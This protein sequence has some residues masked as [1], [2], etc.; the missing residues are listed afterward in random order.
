LKIDRRIV[1]E[2]LI[3]LAT[4][5]LI[6]LVWAHYQKPISYNAGK[7]WEGVGYYQVAEQLLEG[8]QVAAEGP[9]VYRVGT[10]LLVSLLNI[11]DIFLGFQIVNTIANVLTLCLLWFWLRLHLKDSRVR[12]GL[13][14]LFLLQWDTPVHWLYFFPAHT[15]PW[16]WTFL[17]A[18]LICLHYLAQ[19]TNTS[20]WLLALGCLSAVGVVFREVAL[21]IPL[22]LLFLHN[23][24][25]WSERRWK[26]HVPPAMFFLPLLCA[27]LALVLVRVSVVQTDDYSFARTAVQWV[28]TKSLLSYL[29]GW[30]LAYGPVV[31]LPI[32][33]FKQT[34]AFLRQSQWMTVYLLF[35]ALMGYVG[36]SDTERLL[37]WSMPIVF[38]LIGKVFEENAPL[39]RSKPLLLMLIAVEL[40]AVRAFLPTPDYTQ[41]RESHSIPLFTPL[42]SDAYFMDLFSF[43]GTPSVE[44]ISLLQYLAFAGMFGTWIALRRRRL[45]QTVSE[46][47]IITTRSHQKV[48]V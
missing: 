16:L 13:C 33:F 7:G 19:A 46:Q 31:F 18:G 25:R 20:R 30:M 23:P 37:Y 47:A 15:D 35:F 24:L 44:W 11:K 27:L 5:L 12:V 32:I 26:L 48:E 38:I 2:T 45:L 29:H 8:K 40:L 28:R 9:Y 41:G 39:M 42:G 1:G 22:V 34:L 3:L 43:H 6:N 10:P 4:F 21:I 36:G 14:L 17:L